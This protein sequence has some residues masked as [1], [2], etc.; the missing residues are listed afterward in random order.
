MALGARPGNVLKTVL[1]QGAKMALTGVFIG[2][3]GALV[4]TRLMTTLLF[5]VAARYPGTFVAMAA[6]LVLV[7]LLACYLPAR[8][9]M[10]VD[11]IVT[12]RYE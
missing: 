6:L 8:R 2:F 5:G 1:S 9:A 4:L 10:K 3:A 11:P 7:A 12:L